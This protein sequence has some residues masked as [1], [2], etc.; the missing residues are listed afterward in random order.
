MYRLCQ[1]FT[2]EIKPYLRRLCQNFTAEIMSY[3]RTVSYIVMQPFQICLFDLML[4]V[5]GEQLRSFSDASLTLFVM[6]S[7]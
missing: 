3:V 2:D 1:N 4:Y 7:T 5:H 6:D